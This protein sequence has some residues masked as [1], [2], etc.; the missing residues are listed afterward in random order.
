M[1]LN[2]IAGLPHQGSKLVNQVKMGMCAVE[3]RSCN[4]LASNMRFGQQSMPTS[5]G[6][7]SVWWSALM[8]HGL[9]LDCILSCT[10]AVNSAE[11]M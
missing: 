7:R 5:P 11:A 10:V 2:K 4:E 8:P 9:A 1:R 6:D 3:H